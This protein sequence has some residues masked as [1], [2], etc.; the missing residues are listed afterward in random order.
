MTDREHEH[1]ARSTDDDASTDRGRAPEHSCGDPDCEVGAYLNSM[2]RAID[3]DGER[4]VNAQD[5]ARHLR[6]AIEFQ[7]LSVLHGA[8]MSGAF[9][10]NEGLEEVLTEVTSHL[11]QGV[12]YAASILYQMDELPITSV[13]DRTS[14]LV[15]PQEMKIDLNTVPDEWIHPNT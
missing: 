3:H 11:G 1:T 15:A 10:D 5:V 4:Y 12:E 14:M 6:V 8:R 2:V 9:D 7:V 13:D